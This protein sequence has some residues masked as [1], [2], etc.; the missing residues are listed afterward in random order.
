[1]IELKGSVHL[2]LRTR[3]I[4]SR[5]DHPRLLELAPKPAGRGVVPLPPDADDIDDYQCAP[6]EPT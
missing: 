3:A 5:G 4:A 2:Q 1:M 6:D